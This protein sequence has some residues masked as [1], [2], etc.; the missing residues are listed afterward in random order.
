[1]AEE[2]VEAQKAGEEI[3]APA[4]TPDAQDAATEISLNVPPVPSEA[5]ADVSDSAP[6]MRWVV[7]FST[8]LVMTCVYYSLDLPAALHHRSS[9][10]TWK[11]WKRRL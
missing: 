10:T 5:G 6:T 11:Q 3:A 1:M 8:C 2:S 9:K 4:E 7:L